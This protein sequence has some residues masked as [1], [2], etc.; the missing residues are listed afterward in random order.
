MT[1]TY[2]AGAPSVA[3]TRLTVDR[4]L[5]S[6][7]VIAKRII[8]PNQ[9]FLSDTLFRKGTNQGTVLYNKAA[10]SDIYPSRGDV[11]QI[12]PGANFPMVDVEEGDQ[13]VA[14]ST[15]FGAGYYVTDQ[16]KSRNQTDV[17]AKGNRKVRNALLRQD[18]YRCIK[19]FNDN[20]PNENASAIWSSA[21]FLALKEDILRGMAHVKALGLGYSINTIMVNPLVVTEILL[22]PELQTWSP[23]E[24]KSQNPLYSPSI[25]GLFGLNWIE[26][27]FADLTKATLLETQT[28]GVNSVEKEYGVEV[29]REGLRKRDAVLADK[30]SVPVIDEPEAALVIDGVGPV[31]P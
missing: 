6:P 21:N 2:P 5:K 14:V 9:N 24:N 19:A 22:A 28:V 13:L 12:E 17:I 3:G 25:Q 23:R 20:V 10:Q 16:A 29:V 11:E 1:L 7:T 27:E 15:A 30:W 4:L 8:T 26:N 18:A 31:A